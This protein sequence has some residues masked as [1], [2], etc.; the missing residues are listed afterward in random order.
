MKML[1]VQYV[2]YISIFCGGFGSGLCG[3]GKPRAAVGRAGFWYIWVPRAGI[4]PAR[5]F[6]EQGILS[7]SCL[8]IPPPRRNYFLT[9]VVIKLK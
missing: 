8:P 2:V 5:L 3:G 7:P 4:E 9:S 6:N 1:L